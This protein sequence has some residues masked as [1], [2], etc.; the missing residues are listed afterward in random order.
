MKIDFVTSNIKKFQEAQLVLKE[1]KLEQINIDLKEIQG[2]KEEI[3]I[4]KAKEALAQLN[5]PLIVEDISLC[6]NALD[7]LPGPYVKDFLY[8]IGEA[9]IADIV[10]KYDD[11]NVKAV[12]LIAFIKPCIEPVIFEGV[13]DGT[14]VRPRG[15]K[16]LHGKRSWNPIFVPEGHKETF[17]E[18]TMEEHAEMSHRKKA[19]LKLKDYLEEHEQN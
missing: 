7:G 4:E 16:T 12:C 18:M 17:A 14:I 2:T 3:I 10:L 5:K 19:L 8:T 6:C 15:T 9:G 13:I 1:W 11:H